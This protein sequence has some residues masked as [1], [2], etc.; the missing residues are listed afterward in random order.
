MDDME[1]LKTINTYINI[2]NTFENLNYSLKLVFSRGDYELIK[3]YGHGATDLFK[4][5]LKDSL[6]YVKSHASYLK[7]N[8][9]DI[10]ELLSEN[11]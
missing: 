1:M 3:D 11:W 4:L 6:K 7:R 8:G 2:F 5:G 9:M 10:D